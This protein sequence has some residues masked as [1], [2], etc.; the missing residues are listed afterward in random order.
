MNTTATRK[1]NHSNAYGSLLYPLHKYAKRSQR[2]LSKHVLRSLSAV[3][4]HRSILQGHSATGCRCGFPGRC[5][6]GRPGTI[7][8]LMVVASNC[9]SVLRDILFSIF[10][11]NKV[12]TKCTLPPNGQCVFS[13]IIFVKRKQLTL[14]PSG[15][16]RHF[17]AL[18]HLYA[19]L[20]RRSSCGS[21]FHRTA[22]PALARRWV[23]R[24][25]VSDKPGDEDIKMHWE[26]A[27]EGR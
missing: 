14:Y 24:R 26:V 2:R 4:R 7:R 20:C 5:K 22:T 27:I 6:L 19:L 1:I 23:H 11:D 18:E 21:Q 10:P 3:S 12:H 9:I 25:I 8:D 16:T 17:T 15:N 13:Q